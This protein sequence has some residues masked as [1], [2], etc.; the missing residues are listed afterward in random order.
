MM[1]LW[2]CSCCH[3]FQLGP[4]TPSCAACGEEGGLC[5]SYR[6]EDATRFLLARE[7]ERANPKAR[8]AAA[9][10]PV[11]PTVA[12]IRSEMLNGLANDLDGEMD[13]WKYLG[14]LVDWNRLSLGQKRSYQ[15]RVDAVRSAIVDELRMAAS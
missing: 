15:G 11:V 13:E 4:H 10:K 9:K 2:R 6:Y 5:G 1:Q 3:A 7:S 14:D 8:A 12:E